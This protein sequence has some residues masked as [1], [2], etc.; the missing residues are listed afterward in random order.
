MVIKGKYILNYTINREPKELIVKVILEKT[1]EMIKP[2]E[3]L[4]HG[5]LL[6]NN[7]ESNEYDVSHCVNAKYCA[8]KIGKKIKEKLKKES[9]KNKESFRIKKEFVE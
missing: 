8:E 4:Y 9:K 6:I 2:Y 7:K 5:V 1:K 3:N